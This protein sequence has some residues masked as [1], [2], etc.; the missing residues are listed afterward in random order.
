MTEAM[1]DKIVKVVS[2]EDA[3][4]MLYRLTDSV[5]VKPLRYTRAQAILKELVDDG[6]VTVIVL[7]TTHG[8]ADHYSYFQISR[9]LARLLAEKAAADKVALEAQSKAWVGYCLVDKDGI[10]I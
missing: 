6:H 4:H 7:P 2:H 10:M 5:L 3:V 1:T 8:D 9:H